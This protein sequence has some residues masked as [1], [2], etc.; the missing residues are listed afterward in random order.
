V[1]YLLIDTE[2][3]VVNVIIWDGVSRF[4]WRDKTPILESDAP[5]GVTRGWKYIN[6]EWINPRP[7][8]IIELEEP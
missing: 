8:E 1:R 5:L 3:L 2:G 4:N 7:Q 6:G